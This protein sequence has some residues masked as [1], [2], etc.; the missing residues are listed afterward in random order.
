MKKLVLTSLGATLGALA[1]CQQDSSPEL[2]PPSYSPAW[3]PS[4]LAAGPNTW[5][6]PACREC[7]RRR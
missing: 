6:H 1:G 5:N 3:S 2:L 7:S 4:S